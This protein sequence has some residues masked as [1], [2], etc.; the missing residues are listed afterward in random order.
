VPKGA[1][2]EEE[3]PA[4]KKKKPNAYPKRKDPNLKAMQG[5]LFQLLRPM[6]AS[7]THIRDALAKARVGDLDHFE[8]ILA[9]V[10]AAVRKGFDEDADA[11]GNGVERKSAESATDAELTPRQK[12]ELKYKRPWWV[13]QPQIRPM[14]EEAIKNGSL[15]LSKK[16][17]AKMAA[18]QQQAASEAAVT[19]TMIEDPAIRRTDEPVATT[20]PRRAAINPADTTATEPKQGPGKEQELENT[21]SGEQVPKAALVCG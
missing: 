19:T 2:Q 18:Q 4:R 17:I 12:T 21:A 14:P 15:Q 10:E 7:H 8:K 6:L 9:M 13:C 3:G 16:A 11:E 20:D 5:H 1:E